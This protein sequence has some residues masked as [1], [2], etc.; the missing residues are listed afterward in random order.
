MSFGFNTK[1][2]GGIAHIQLDGRLIDK[3]E[4]ENLFGEVNGHLERS[5]L[6]FIIDLESLEYMN[7]S[8]LNVLVNILTKVRNA[9]GELAICRVPDRINEL[10]VMTKLNTVFSV[11]ETLDD[12]KDLVSGSMQE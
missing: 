2:E 11:T 6:L 10:L 7:S 12:A 3:D 8:G 5:V 9:G 1:L 4:A